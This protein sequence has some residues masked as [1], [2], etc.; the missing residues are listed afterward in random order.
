[1]WS[2]GKYLRTG[3]VALGGVWT[4]YKTGVNY[5]QSIIHTFGV[6]S[7]KDHVLNVSR[8]Y[9]A[10]IASDRGRTYRMRLRVASSVFVP[11]YLFL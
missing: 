3:A 10:L 2:F 7:M 4:R 11:R 1:M 9:K 8:T 6:V 5:K